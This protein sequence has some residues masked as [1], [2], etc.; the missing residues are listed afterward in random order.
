MVVIIVQLSVTKWSGV[1]GLL[2]HFCW[3]LGSLIL[4]I[5]I[6]WKNMRISST[7]NGN[8]SNDDDDDDDDDILHMF[9]C[10]WNISW[11]LSILSDIWYVHAYMNDMIVSWSKNLEQR[12][13]QMAS[14]SS[15]AY[16]TYLRIPGM[17]CLIHSKLREL[18]S[19]VSDKMVICTVRYSWRFGDVIGDI[20]F[21]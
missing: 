11:W 16:R 2:T 4:V 13:S 7:G 18:W 1:L 6:V 12:A 3:W 14:R 8:T 19:K 10:L 21:V 20:L 17:C 9:T 5:R 15:K